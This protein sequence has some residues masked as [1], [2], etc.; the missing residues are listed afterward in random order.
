M[1]QSNSPPGWGISRQGTGASHRNPSRIQSWV[2]GSAPAVQ[3]ADNEFTPDNYSIYHLEW[4]DLKAWLEAKFPGL[5]LPDRK[6]VNKDAYVFDIPRKLN[7]DDKKKIA[8]MRDEIY[9]RKEEAAAA[10]AAGPGGRPP[11]NPQGANNNA[12][13]RVRSP[14]R[15]RR[16]Y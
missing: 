12:R 5:Q 6:K 1:P 8:A 10:A 14:E 11:N 15:P 9:H 2:T 4:S 16:D 7:A 3:Q 13:Q